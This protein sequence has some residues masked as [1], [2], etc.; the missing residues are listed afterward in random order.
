MN[1]IKLLPP[2]WHIIGKNGLCCEGNCVKNKN[3]NINNNNGENNNTNGNG[4]G[5]G[6]T[7]PGSITF[8]TSGMYCNDD[9]DD[10]KGPLDTTNWIVKDSILCGEY[11]GNKDDDILHFK[12][13]STLL[14]S[15]I[16]VFVCLQEQ[17][18]LKK[19]RPYREDILKLSKEKGIDVDSITFV[20]FPIED[21]GIA[22]NNEDL[23][24]LIERLLNLLSLDNKVYLHCWAGRGRTGIVGACLLGRLYQVT[25][26]EALRRTQDCYQQRIIGYGESPEYH[27]QK[28]QVIKYLRSKN[29][30]TNS[31]NSNN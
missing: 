27:P 18:E 29:E 21:G 16:R 3:E 19:F 4:N 26:L 11:P 20:H 6:I 12:T 22:E 5:N 1:Y 14:D 28:M 15:G 10:M 8:N 17:D 9:T 30:L 23:V 13:L 7:T 31:N 2:R 25:G 24:D